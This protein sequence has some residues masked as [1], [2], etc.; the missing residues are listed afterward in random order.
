MLVR[1]LLIVHKV[2]SFSG[3]AA[4]MQVYVICTYFISK[5]Y[6]PSMYYKYEMYNVHGLFS[7]LAFFCVQFIKSIKKKLRLTFTY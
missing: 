3:G 4:W 1:V 2:D 7:M 6:I 5:L